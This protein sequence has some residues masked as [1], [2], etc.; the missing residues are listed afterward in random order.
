MEHVLITMQQ[1]ADGNSIELRDVLEIHIWLEAAGWA[2][3]ADVWI[4]L[5]SLHTP[6][7]IMGHC[8]FLSVS[9]LHIYVQRLPQIH[10]ASK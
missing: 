3:V 4:S 6:S 8:L 7:T 10:V 9:Q 5:Y 1:V 2:A